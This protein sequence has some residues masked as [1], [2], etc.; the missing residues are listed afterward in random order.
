MLLRAELYLPWA[1]MGPL[2]RAPFR[3]EVSDLVMAGG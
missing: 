2:E 1:V 3:R